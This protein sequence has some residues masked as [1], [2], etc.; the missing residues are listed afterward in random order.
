MPISMLNKISGLETK[1][2]NRVGS[3]INSLF[4]L[5][6]QRDL[7]MQLRQM[8]ERCEAHLQ[9]SDLHLGKQKG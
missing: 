1:Y 2:Q 3:A 4:L 5:R 9:E 7:E 8:R 6:F